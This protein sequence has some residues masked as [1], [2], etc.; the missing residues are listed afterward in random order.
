MHHL[1][2]HAGLEHRQHVRVE[3]ALQAVGG[4]GAERHRGE[5]EK[6]G[7]QQEGTQHGAILRIDGGRS[8]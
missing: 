2:V 5:A 6:G 4:E 7:E 8:L 3:L 1:V